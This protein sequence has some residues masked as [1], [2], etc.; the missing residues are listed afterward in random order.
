HLQ[1]LRGLSR[2]WGGSVRR[3]H[4]I[5]LRHRGA[6]QFLHHA[7]R[8]F[9]RRRRQ[10]RLRR[11]YLA[12]YAGVYLH[13]RGWPCAA[14]RGLGRLK[15][16][17][18]QEDGHLPAREIQLVLRLR[19]RRKNFWF[20]DDG[21]NQ[22]DVKHH[23]G[24]VSGQVGLGAV[25]R[26]RLGKQVDFSGQENIGV[27]NLGRKNVLRGSDDFRRRRALRHGHALVHVRRLQGQVAW[28][29]DDEV[30]ALYA[31][32]N[33][34]AR[35][36]GFQRQRGR[37]VRASVQRNNG[38]HRWD[39]RALIQRGRAPPRRW[40]V[41]GRRTGIQGNQEARD[42]FSV[43]CAAAN[44]TSWTRS[45]CSWM[46]AITRPASSRAARPAS[47]LTR[48]SVCVRTTSTKDSSSARSGSTA[49]AGS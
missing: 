14:W 30:F 48:G 16:P 9:W 34:G 39:E 28:F 37:D 3:G 11:R 49:G 4:N 45:P 2:F 26:A 15:S 27:D 38:Q 23:R 40:D 47:P 41:H 25:L 19:A 35:S 6:R 32:R 36:N 12:D 21:Q 24:N 31:P 18:R 46:L 33:D 42:H 10:R 44:A 7:L 1:R 22:Q 43:F 5:G 8:L 20:D 13:G 17:W 29:F